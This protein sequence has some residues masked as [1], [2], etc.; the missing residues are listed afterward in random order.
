MSIHGALAALRGR[1]SGVQYPLEVSDA[2][3]AR[4]TRR[5]MLAQLDD[6][7]LPRLDQLDAPLLAV[8]G[9]STGAGKSTLVNSLVRRK[10][11]DAGVLRPTTRSPVLVHHPDDVG[12]FDELRVLPDLPRVAIHDQAGGALRLVADDG[13]PAGV[14]ILDAPDVDSVVTENRTLAAQLLAAADLWLFVTTAARY[15]DAVPWDFL[16]AA[17]DRQAAVAVVL[18]RVAPDAVSEVRA[19]L[20]AMLA[21]HGLGDAPLL[22]VEETAPDDAGLLPEEAVASVRAWLDGLAAD[23]SARNEIVRRTLDGAISGALR[24]VPMLADAAD[25]QVEALTL[26]QNE[27]AHVYGKAAKRIDAASADGSLLRGEVLARWQDFVGTGDFMRSLE[28]RVGRLRDK[29][30]AFLRGRPQPAAAVEEAIES[31]VA[32][33]IVEEA[34]RAAEK[35]D[36]RWRDSAA[37]RALLAGDDLSRTANDL[38]ERSAKTV[39]EWQDAVLAMVR[40]EG[41]DKRFNA[42]LLSFGVNGLGLALMIVVFASTAGLTGA[43][44]GVAGG[45]AVVGQKLLEA[46][47]GDEA[48]RRLAARARADLSQ[49]VEELLRT[50]SARFTDRLGGLPVEAGA[51]DAL[52]A[53]LVTVEQAREDAE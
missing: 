24:Q 30:A 18:D 17:A 46:F 50:E 6:Y 48:V 37:G 49:R 5:D 12:W 10:V 33:M 42:R 47:F 28:A 40:A 16:R 43:E 14:A 1:L 8:V 35:A 19:H 26:L 7:I 22:V 41:A 27:I 52:R 9:G 23:E 25:H 32:S 31:G 53:A 21:E 15:S 4:G 13:L 44:V 51:G 34:N 29:V 20:A 11:S 39:R 45:T 2:E 3:A 38:P 36:G